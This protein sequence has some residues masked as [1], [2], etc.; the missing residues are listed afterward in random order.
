MALSFILC[1][2][3]GTSVIAAS[4][5]FIFYWLPYCHSMPL[6]NSAKI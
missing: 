3:V 4:E 6:N 1:T 5:A 2:Q